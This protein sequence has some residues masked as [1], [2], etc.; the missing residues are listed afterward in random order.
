MNSGTEDNQGCFQTPDFSRGVNGLLPVIAQDIEDGT[1]LML[2]WMNEEAW[3]Q[4]TT[5]G[6]ATYFSRSRNGLWRKGDTSGHVQHV[7]EARID[8]D[9]D[10][11]LLLVRQAGAACHENYRSCF[12]RTVIGDGQIRINQPRVS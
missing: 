12:F 10:T 11:I 8:C 4:T 3:L 2:A 7:V 1:V 5:S 9:A 6:R